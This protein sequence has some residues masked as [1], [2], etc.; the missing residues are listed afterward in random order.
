MKPL[1]A[2]VLAVWLV[3]VMVLGATGMFVPPAGTPPLPIG[4]G[5]LVPLLV[6]LTA[7]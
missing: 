2:V 4:L 7:Y 3:C 6:F 5:V 1:V